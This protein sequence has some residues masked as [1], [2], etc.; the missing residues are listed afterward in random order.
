MQSVSVYLREASYF[1]VV[2]HGSG[3]GD[4]CIASGPVMTLPA[5]ADAQALGTAILV[6]LSQSTNAVPWPSDWKK[7]TEPLLLA[8]KAKTWSAF[9][10][11]ATSARVDRS[12]PAISVRPSRRDKASFTDLAE[13]VTQLR[14]SDPA[15]LGSVVAA[16]LHSPQ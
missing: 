15:S 3:G 11:R 9:A 14:A 8:A 4:P 10:K 6:A 16:S 13:K 1:I 5:D 12:G 2:I 7:V